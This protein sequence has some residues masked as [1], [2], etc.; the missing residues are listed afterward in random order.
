MAQEVSIR[1]KINDNFKDV[2]VDAASL[3]KAIDQVSDSSKELSSSFVKFAS[4]SK[5]AEGAASAFGQLNAVFSDLTAAYAAQSV[6][7]ARLSQAMSNTMGATEAEIQSI[8][9]LCWEQ[10]RLGVIGE[11]VQLA[12]AQELATY[13]EYSD[14]LK[15]IIPVMNDMAAQ[16]YGL[17]ASAESVTQIA[18]MLGKVMNGQTEALSRYGYKFDEAQKQILLFGNEADRAAVLA[19][20][21]GQS[22]GGMNEALAQTPAGKMQQISNVLGGWKESLGKTVQS[23]I[24][25]VAGFNAFASSAATVTRLTQAIKALDLASLKAKIESMGLAVAQRTQSMAA[26]MLG[27]SEQVAAVATGALRVK[28]IALQA[29]MT[30]G[31]SV[32]ITAVIGLITRLASKSHEAAGAAEEA[33][34]AYMAYR[35]TT[36]DAGAEIRLYTA[37]LEDLI[38]HHRNDANMVEE[39]NEKYG[40]AFG[41][42]NTAES[43]YDILTNKSEAYCRQLGYEAQAK[44]YS[45]QVAALQMEKDK[46]DAAA[47]GLAANGGAWRR[48]FFQNHMTKEAKDIIANA[49]RIDSALKEAQGNFDA[50]MKGMADAQSELRKDMEDTSTVASWQTM[51][52]AQLTKAIQT[53]KGVVESLIGVDE[54]HAAEEDKTLKLM[55]ARKARLE[56]AYGMGKQSVKDNEDKFDGSKL[57]EGATSY[58]ELG[59]NIK[60]YQEQLKSTHPDEMAAIAD[61]N[62]KINAL[63]AAQAEIERTNAMLS[64]GEI[65]LDEI[66]KTIDAEWAKMLSDT[67]KDLDKQE[68]TFMNHLE[69]SMKVD[70]QKLNALVQGIDPD[71]AI[72]LST[73][74]EGLEMARKNIEDL[75]GMLAVARGDEKKSLV[76]AIEYWKQYAVQLGDTQT[77]GEKATGMLENISSIAHN[78]SGIV[79]ESASGWLSWGANVLSAVAA[80]LPAIASIIGGNIAQAFSGAAAQSQTVGF[81]FNLVALA[82]SFA[83]VSAAVAS[84]PKFADG[85]I[86]KGP[87]L[88][89]FGEYPGAATN[90]EVVAPLDRLESLLGLPDRGGGQ[91]TFRIRGCDLEGILKKR[92]S[93]TG[94]S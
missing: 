55:E 27:I 46:N 23:I 18:T 67:M 52:L 53:Q 54:K 41:Y 70:V 35:D 7:Q 5:L 15:T 22:V 17:G 82:S 91:V 3:G 62:G 12:A 93:M 40:E 72:T 51:S 39:L 68:E 64:G 4:I 59:N 29:T 19:E 85:A 24:P 16:Q 92:T 14:S 84:I 88:G 57:I 43:W 8:K 90:P 45:A 86:A 31:L 61:L 69:N 74:I 36:R 76:E 48:G 94:R 10:Q 21:V 77:T 58:N 34:E 26:R 75:R 37:K 11:E 13:L 79:G 71:L 32:A 87:T 56:G 28:I 65:D 66:G 81:P 83:A 42:Y 80:A 30:L 44:V 1:I 9:D 63:K 47:R 49:K 73:R 20:V 60:F 33:D 2:T 50:A 38:K 78:M 89:L 6:A 25:I